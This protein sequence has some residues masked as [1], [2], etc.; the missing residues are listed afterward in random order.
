MRPRT[1]VRFPPPPLQRFEAL[2]GLDYF[3][4]NLSDAWYVESIAEIPQG[5]RAGDSPTRKETLNVTALTRTGET[6]TFQAPYVRSLGRIRFSEIEE[7]VGVPLFF[8]PFYRA[9]GLEPPSEREQVA[10][11]VELEAKK[12]ADADEP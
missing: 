11:L 4:F 9:W 12:E 6:K 3:C 5:G 2:R 8:A 1:R 7:T 10:R